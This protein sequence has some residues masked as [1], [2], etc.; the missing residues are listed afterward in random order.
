MNDEYR[1]VTAKVT[2]ANGTTHSVYAGAVT[3]KDDLAN[4]KRRARPVAVEE[5]AHRAGTTVEGARVV[6]EIEGEEVEEA[7]TAKR[8]LHFGVHLDSLGQA[9]VVVAQTG[10]VV[11]IEG[12][13]W[14]AWGEPVGQEANDAT[15]FAVTVDTDEEHEMLLVEHLKASDLVLVPMARTSTIARRGDIRIVTT[16]REDHSRNVAEIIG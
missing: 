15:T 11:T 1:T 8:T 4:L 7:G 6:W 13:G 14:N 2:L 12:T 3:A 16:D 9:A 5:A 10:H